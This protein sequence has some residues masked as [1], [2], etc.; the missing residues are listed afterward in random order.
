MKNNNKVTLVNNAENIIKKGLNTK[1]FTALKISVIERGEGNHIT[2]FTISMQNLITQ[3]GLV[4][5]QAVANQKMKTKTYLGSIEYL[6]IK[7]LKDTQ[8]LKHLKATEINENANQVKH[9]IK[10][11]R[12]ISVKDSLY[13][14]NRLVN[15]LTAVLNLPILKQA[16]IR[17]NNKQAKNTIFEEKD[18]IKYELVGKYRFKFFLSPK[19]EF[20]RYSKEAIASLD[21]TWDKK[22]DREA[23][24]SIFSSVT[25][26]QLMHMSF[27]LSKQN[28]RTVK[29]KVTENDFERNSKTIKI[30]VNILVLHHYT[31]TE[32]E[33]VKYTSGFIFKRTNTYN[34]D[35]EVDKTK[36]EGKK[37]I[38][39]SNRL[40]SINN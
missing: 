22:Y 6:C 7:I 3:L 21:I 9:S 31:E 1:E 29:F 33:E 4:I 37:T 40:T 38:D 20:D 28:S 39:I 5:S 23:K 25:N 27:G 10:K 24:I 8:L 2:I 26:K 16:Q 36:V 35:V 34:L 14:Y 19:Y 11:N 30:K 13:Y 32:V 18:H 12:E 17:L 15:S